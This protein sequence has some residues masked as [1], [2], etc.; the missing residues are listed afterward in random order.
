[1]GKELHMDHDAP[2]KATYDDSPPRNDIILGLTLVSLMTLVG[3]H[4]VFGSYFT[5]QTE[6]QVREKILT[7]GGDEVAAL[8]TE[9]ARKLHHGKVPIEQAMTALAQE[10]RGGI[11]VI[12]PR[13]SEET[14][15]LK[16]WSFHPA[17]EAKK[18]AVEARLAAPAGEGE[19]EQEAAPAAEAREQTNDEEPA[20]API[21]EGAL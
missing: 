16:G 14:D 15:A 9:E 19:E 17:F 12:A 7:R 5:D 13:P 10:G 6:A 1:M 3:L 2:V 21:L 18:A 11:P 4:F 8:R 20:A